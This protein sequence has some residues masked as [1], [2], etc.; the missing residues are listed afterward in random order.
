MESVWDSGILT[1][2][3]PLLRQLESKLASYLSVPE[4]CCLTNAGLGLQ[5]VF[6]AMGL[7]GEVI[8]TPFSYAATTSCLLWEG[9]TPVFVD[10]DTQSFCLDAALVE[11]AITPRTSA[12]LATHVYGFPGDVETLQEIADRHGLKLIYDAAHAFGVKHQ[13]QDLSLYGDASVLSFHATKLFHSCEGGAVISRDAELLK[14][15]EW[16]LR[17]GHNGP[18]KFH[19]VGINAKMSELHAAMGLT[20]LDHINEILAARKSAYE[21][22]VERLSILDE[23][24]QIPGPPQQATENY[25]YFPILFETEKMLRDCMQR[26]SANNIHPRRYFHPLLSEVYM[27]QPSNLP[28]AQNV[29]SRVL[30][31]PLSAQTTTVNIDRVCDCIDAGHSQKPN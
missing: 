7:R 27:S 13:G 23:R 24:L 30:C 19:G 4:V 5:L 22:Y 1:N 9:L 28:V 3:G 25:A 15:V 18:D 21:L 20:V 29:A 26:M 2:Q 12:I 17:Y 6:K 31:L 14:K 8:T 10:I 16:M 11:A